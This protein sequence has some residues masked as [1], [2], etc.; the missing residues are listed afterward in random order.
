M[1]D[2]LTLPA[3]LMINAFTGVEPATAKPSVQ[4][5]RWS[6]ANAPPRIRAFLKAS[7]RADPRDWRDPRVGWGLVL[8]HNPD[9]SPAE[10]ASAKDAPEPIQALVNERGKNGQPA[11]VLRYK[12]SSSHIGFL[13]RDGADL[14]V[15]QSAFGT[16]FAAV[17]RYLLIYGTPTQIPWEVQYTLNATRYVG[18][19][20][21]AGTALE[22]YVQALM[23]NWKDNSADLA[24]AL[25][26]STDHGPSDITRLMRE[27]VASPVVQKLRGDPTIGP[28]TQFFDGSKPGTATVKTLIESLS[29]K[30]PGFILTTSHGM[31]GPL[32]NLDLMT[33]QM[34]ALVDSDR[35]LV[36]PKD[37][38]ENWKPSGAIWYAHACCSAGSDAHTLFDGLVEADSLVDQ[39]L[40]GVAKAGARVSPLPNALLGASQPLRAFIG[41]VE[42]T[43]N[44]TLEQKITEQFTTAPLTNALYEEL[45]QPSPI[46][47]AMSSMYAQL[48]GIYADYD[49]FSR[50]PDQANML[51]R[52]LVARDIQSTVILGD[53]TAML[54][55]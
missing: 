37:I 28:N 35:S 49:R 50:V 23:N 41:H 3:S 36:S 51:Y 45:F 53:P 10:L 26:W 14:P 4:A 32:D 16:E 1:A 25:V 29:A 17:P 43:F 44:W 6:F 19:L 46:G 12:S 7:P 18:R 42:P 40:K 38:L 22:N 31:T 24:S 27:A 21:L 20:D 11:L 8:P 13:H 55:L 33:V 48:G 47:M 9:L 5:K 54:P 30:R 39:V 52:L 2:D 34:G 15:N